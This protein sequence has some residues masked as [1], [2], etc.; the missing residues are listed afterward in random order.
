MMD[1]TSYNHF[2]LLKTSETFLEHARTHKEGSFYY[3]LGSIVFCAFAIEAFINH[4]GIFKEGD[5]WKEQ[6]NKGRWITIEEKLQTLG[7]ELKNHKDKFYKIRDIRHYISHGR[8]DTK[9]YEKIKK[10]IDIQDYMQTD[11]EKQIKLVLAEDMFKFTKEFMK[12]INIESKCGFS[13]IEIFHIAGEG[14]GSYY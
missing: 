11:F 7:V 5:N 14:G 13:N 1:Y 3:C 8:P 2:L 10:D 9:I 4:C 12:H 6:N